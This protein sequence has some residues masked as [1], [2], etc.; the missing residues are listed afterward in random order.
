MLQPGMVKIGT[1][2]KELEIRSYVS[3]LK[4]GAYS[5]GTMWKVFVFAEELAVGS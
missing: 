1:L 3:F 2:A 5:G 4:F